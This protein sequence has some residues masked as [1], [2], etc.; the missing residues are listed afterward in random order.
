MPTKTAKPR[1]QIIPYSSDALCELLSDK[2]EASPEVVRHRPHFS[3]FTEYFRASDIAAKTIIAENNYIDRDFLEDYSS[4]HV[5]C[6]YP[7]RRACCRLHFFSSELTED[8]INRAL[9]SRFTKKLLRRIH[10]SYLGFV[11]VKPLPQTIIGRTCLETYSEDGGASDAAVER[12]RELVVELGLWR[13]IDRE[14]V[15]R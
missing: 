12:L 3:Y 15:L 8:E 11:V 14:V 7:Y 2:S 10:D 6:F 1:L 4:F 5:R 13:D 9:R